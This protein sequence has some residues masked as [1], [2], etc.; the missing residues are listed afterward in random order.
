MIKICQYCKKEYRTN[1]KKRKHCSRECFHKNRDITGKNN[2]RWNG[3]ESDGYI[4]ELARQTVI[5]S[6]KNPNICEVCLKEGTGTKICIHHLNQNRQDNRPENLKVL[7]RKH[8]AE[9]HTQPRYICYCLV[10]KKQIIRIKSHYKEKS[11]KFCS[12]KCFQNWKKRKSMVI[13]DICKQYKQRGAYNLCRKCYCKQYQLAN[14]DKFR[15][16]N[17]KSRLKKMLR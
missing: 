16:Y 8:H 10:C 17:Q 2:P 6:G 7:C 9:I 15:K 1:D 13:C 12:I 3:G 11:K 5:K 14:L 4:Y